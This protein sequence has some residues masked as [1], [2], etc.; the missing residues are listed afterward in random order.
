MARTFRR[1][2]ASRPARSI[3]TTFPAVTAALLVLGVAGSA[4]AGDPADT[5]LDTIKTALARNSGGKVNPDSVAPSP[6]PGIY[7]V[8]N[9]ME[10]FYT[11]ATGRYAFVD[12][13]LVDTVEKQDL[14][15]RKLD[16]LSAIPFADLPLEL[17]IKTVRGDGSRKLAVF[18]DPACPVC[19]SMQQSLAQLDNI[20]IYT[21]TYPVIAPESIPAAVA[22]WCAAADGRK[23][24]WQAYMDGA[25]A[26]QHIE[27]HCDDAMTVVHRIVEF[28]RARG[29]RNT[30]TLVLADGRRVVG[31]L[32]GTELES[33]V[34]RAAGDAR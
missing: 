14:T 8:V 23:P 9:G 7:E 28:G 31:A 1:T 20:T 3:G 22:T 27:P 16:M 18:E 21:F 30:P 26:P 10:V 17:A 29:I 2:Y 32:P 6:I 11:D 13:R 19:R 5:A 25:P 34:T 15:Q 12:G 4:E 33:A 24:R